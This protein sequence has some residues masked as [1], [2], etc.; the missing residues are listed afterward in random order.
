MSRSM[1]DTWQKKGGS[2]AATHWAR[3]CLDLLGGCGFGS[4]FSWP[5]GTVHVSVHRF[6]SCNAVLVKLFLSTT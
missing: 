1:A 6:V 2:K 4:L 3:G 5:T